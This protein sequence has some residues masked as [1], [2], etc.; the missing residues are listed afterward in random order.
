MTPVL[1]PLKQWHLEAI[2]LSSQG[3]S[4]RK[5]AKKLEVGKSSVNDL[6]S[7]VG[8]TYYGWKRRKSHRDNGQEPLVKVGPKI[9]F[10][11]IETKPILGHVWR[12]F[13]QN[14]GLN[15]IQED[16]SILSFCAKWKGSEDIIYRDLEGQ[17]DFE[18]DSTLLQALWDLLNEADFVVG[19]N[20][21]RFDVKKINARLV[22][23]GYPKPST[24]RQI[25]TLEVAK[26]QFG[27]TSNKL[28]YMTDKLCVTHK[29]LLH[30]N[31][32]GHVLWAECMK[33]N[34]LAWAEMKEYNIND[35]LC[36]EELYDIFSSW[37]D[38]LPNFDVYVNE[39]LDMTAWEHDGFHYSNM[40]KYKRYRNKVTGVQRRSRV[41]E[42]SKEK[43][44]QLLANIV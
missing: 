12:L 33:G 11:D 44:Q 41:N 4:S 2:E 7:K 32:P 39:L 42:L 19:Q 36:L 1:R 23:N 40:G 22:M 37:D 24:F 10:I 9:L 14:V 15:Q 28:E 16:W 13:D 34:P 30:K 35:V 17:A 6:L 43:R 3:V 27:F 26:R 18:D 20:S 38:K 21:K 5:I 25:D 29:K 8:G 31:F